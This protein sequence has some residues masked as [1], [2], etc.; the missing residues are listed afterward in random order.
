MPRDEDRM[1]RELCAKADEYD[2]LDEDAYKNDLT[3]Q[4]PEER[5]RKF[6]DSTRKAFRNMLSQ[7]RFLS[8]KQ[9][10][11]IRAIYERVFDAPTYENLASSGKLVRGREVELLVD[12]MPK[13]KKP[14]QRKR[15]DE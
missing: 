6:P 10:S 15:D 11:W 12:V 5:Q 9:A 4:L 8:E 2:A 13:P 1:L 7:S 3:T 14:P